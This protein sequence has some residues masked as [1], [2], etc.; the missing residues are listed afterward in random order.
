MKGKPWSVD[1]EKQLREM[2][3][4]GKSV[5]VIAETFGKTQNAIRQKMIKLELKEEKKSHSKVFS[6]SNLELP[7]DLPSIEDQ[8]KVLVGALNELKT[9]GL[10]QAE[11][12]RLR[13]IIQGVKVY[14]ELCADYVNYRA[15]EVKV[16]ELI[17]ELE[18]DG[19]DRKEAS[20]VAGKARTP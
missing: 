5:G 8:L 6:S 20:G 19:K 15:L 18:K 10:D 1:E 7:E 3:Q 17:R 2:V 16:E 13:S 11:V 4:V 9:R 14:K 12:L